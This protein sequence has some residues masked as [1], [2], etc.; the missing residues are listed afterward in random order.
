MDTLSFRY[1]GKAT[2]LNLRGVR[3]VKGK[4]FTTQD[5]SL[6]KVLRKRKDVE[7]VE[8]PKAEPKAPPAAETP[9]GNEAAIVGRKTRSRKKDA[10]GT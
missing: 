3:L 10:V 4:T 5:G 8:T 2:T 6:V 9:V 1:N 7:E